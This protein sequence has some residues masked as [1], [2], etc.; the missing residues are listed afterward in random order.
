MDMGQTTVR[1]TETA[2]N[3]VDLNAFRLRKQNSC[4]AKQE[5]LASTIP[6]QLDTL[7]SKLAEVVKKGERKFLATL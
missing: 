4:S 2:T 5:E 6:N 3:V 7:I 1:A